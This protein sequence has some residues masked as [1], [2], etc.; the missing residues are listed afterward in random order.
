[1][2]VSY[3]VRLVCLCLA[4]FFLVNAALS[5]AARAAAPAAIRVAE[6]MR[7]RVATR[8]LLTLRLL[9]LSASLFVVL[10]LCLPSYLWWEPVDSGERI[11]LACLA[12][13][14]LGLWL[15]GAALC[16]VARSM[17]LS[18]AD[19]RRWRR[20]GSDVR[21]PETR[22]PILLMESEEP[23][24]AQ[25]GL[26]RPRI[27]ISRGVL[28]ALS[29]EQLAAALRHEGEHW[30]SRDNLKRLLLL[31]APDIVPFARTQAVVDRAWSRLSEWAA[32]DYAVEGDSGRSLTLASALV[33][34]ARMGHARPL[35]PLMASLV[36]EDEELTRR[37]DR[38]LHGG[39]AA[40]PR[41]RRLRQL[42][43]GA[44]LA[45]TAA[46]VAL[47]LQPATFYAVHRLLEHLI[48]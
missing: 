25:A 23:L 9:P 30:T 37:V 22:L 28:S 43:A 35:A 48:R 13:A 24:L 11:G 14:G 32:D 19:L 21:T 26:L 3:L 2:S 7:P 10:G 33:R 47:L 16:R 4:A 45:T 39:S 44:A 27:V 8:W 36:G 5:A 40:Q 1:M 34:M 31:L 38:L 12:A 18:V 20:L 41:K 42:L 15:W 29:E 6:T 46:L 17:A